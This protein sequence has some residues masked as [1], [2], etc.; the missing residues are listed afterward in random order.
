MFPSDNDNCPSTGTDIKITASGAANADIT[1]HD[2]TLGELP[3]E[4]GKNWHCK[5]KISAPDLAS[6]AIDGTTI[7][8]R[9][10]NGWL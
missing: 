2:F 9:E 3:F 7:D 8:E 5:W 10:A 6:V 4:A 1:R